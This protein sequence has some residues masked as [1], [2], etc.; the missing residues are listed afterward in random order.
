MLSEICRYLKNWFDFNQPKY[1][2]TFTISDGQLNIA[3]KIQDSQYY[4][5]VG[6]VFNDGVYQ[7][8][9]ESLKDETFTGA[10]WLM[11]IPPEVITLV[12]EIKAW[13]SKYGGLGSENMSPFQSESFAGY[14]YTKASGGSSGGN[15][16]SWQGAFADRLGR[17]KKI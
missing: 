8:G 1:F 9:E 6:S 13:Q 5:I 12:E 14:S 16:T 10:V 11:A 3:D 15:T 2:D 4:R 7:R 17:W